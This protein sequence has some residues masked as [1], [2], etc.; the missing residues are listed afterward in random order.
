MKANFSYYSHM[1]ENGYR[2]PWVWRQNRYKR[3]IGSN[4]PECEILHFPPRPI[5]PDC[6]H[7]SRRDVSSRI[8]ID[9]KQPKPN[10]A[11]VSSS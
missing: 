4:C 9:L 1:T 6:G 8:E 2:A 3:L 5:C 10:V 11:Q 7:N